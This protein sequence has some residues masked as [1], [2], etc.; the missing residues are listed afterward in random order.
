[1]RFAPVIEVLT[2]AGPTRQRRAVAVLKAIGHPN[3]IA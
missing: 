1:M 3:V 2:K